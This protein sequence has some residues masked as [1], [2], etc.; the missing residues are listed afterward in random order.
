MTDTLSTLKVKKRS[1]RTAKYDIKRISRAVAKAIKAVNKEERQD[2]ADE[3][4][5]S[6]DRHLRET[7]KNPIHVEEIQDTVEREL[8]NRGFYEYAKE[9]ILYRE[10][11]R[12][13]R[14]LKKTMNIDLIDSYIS[15]MDWRVREN[16]NSPYSL[17]A[18]NFNISSRV[19]ENY[20]LN[21]IYPR[22][23]REAHINGDV[24]CHDLGMLSGYCNGWDLYQLLEE[25]FR[26]SSTA[27]IVCAPPKHFRTAL[28]QVVNFFF[29]LQ[30]EVAGA[31][32]FSSFDTYLAPFVHAD[33]LDYEEVKQCLQNFLF[34]INIPTRAGSQIPFT[35]ITLDV[36]IP[37]T[38]ANDTALVGG[39]PYGQYGDFQKEVDMINQAFA[40]LMLEGDVLG[41]GFTFPIPTYNITEDVDISHPSVRKIFEMTAKFGSP[42]FANFI[43]SDMSP[44]DVRSMC[45][46]LRLDLTDLKKRGGGLFG[47]NPLT[48]SIAV[49]T[50]NLSRLGYLSESR[51]EYFQRL[52]YLV[53]LAVKSTNIRREIVESMTEKGLYP[54]AKHYLTG[55]KQVRDSYWGNH[56][57]TVG[58]V[59]MNEAC[60]NHLG[61]DISHP[62][63]YQLAKDTLNFIRDK[64]V[65]YQKE[66]GILYNLE[67]T[68]AEGA[69][70]RLALID[71]KHYPDIIVANEKEVREHG[72]EP[73][74]TNSTFLPMGHTGNLIE[75]LEHQSPLQ[76]LYTGGTVFHMF[77]GEHKPDP[78]ACGHLIKRVFSEYE[79]P[80]M[81]L[82]PTYSI[83]PSHGYI[84][85]QHN[86]CP[87]C[88]TECEVYSR[89][90]GYYRPVSNWNAGKQAEFADRALFDSAFV[91]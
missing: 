29:T 15:K 4:A 34:N 68:P 36:T 22:E 63:G 2:L 69:S 58:V 31:Q 21:K 26:S 18:M 75:L 17:Q 86:T 25:G 70:Y 35:N 61:V 3:I 76:S 24:H 19:T 52:G 59:G 57:G 39:K 33:K 64:L 38:L 51:E 80:Y 7:G 62:D 10:Q 89:V 40:E 50:I 66:N 78:E 79:L 41:R 83:C 14:E 74:Y 1:G 6:V 48:G 30:G 5:L 56:F 53:D 44:E 90:V 43:S 81:T 28:G 47:S 84:F 60:L 12:Q 77:V 20:W 85:G 71:K 46:R 45:C 54:Y 67:A 91:A 23:I 16:A 87:Q 88:G 27:H 55:V 9:Y 49:C 42:Y 37:N 72:A 82:T 8:V 32:A 73:Y 13:A 11:H 65:E